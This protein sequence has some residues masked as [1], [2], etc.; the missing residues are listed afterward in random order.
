M[1]DKIAMVERRVAV[2]VEYCRKYIVRRN[3]CAIHSQT[4]EEWNADAERER[5]AVVAMCDV[6]DALGYEVCTNFPDNAIRLLDEDGPLCK[7]TFE[8]VKD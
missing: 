4:W 1:T 3:K 2:R 5:A 8:E 6:M 7:I